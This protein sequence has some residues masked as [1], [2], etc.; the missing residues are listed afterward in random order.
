MGMTEQEREELRVRFRQQLND[1]HALRLSAFEQKRDRVRDRRERKRARSRQAEIAQLQDEIRAEFYETH[2]YREYI[3][4]AGRRHLV[5]PEE[6]EWRSSAKR[7]RHKKRH[8][9]SE[10]PQR[11]RILAMWSAMLF[12]AVIAGLLLAK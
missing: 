9:R 6:F 4:G 1:E 7:R 8:I 11:T 10:V 2:D 3:D 12:V 5:P